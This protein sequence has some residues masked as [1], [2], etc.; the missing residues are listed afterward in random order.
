MSDEPRTDGPRHAALVAA[1]RVIRREAARLGAE[2][3]GEA[4]DAE[5]L[6]GE[7]SHGA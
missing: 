4:P 2:G 7:D 3:C 1:W 5:A 6:R